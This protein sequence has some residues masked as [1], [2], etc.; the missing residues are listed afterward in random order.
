[1]FSSLSR[2]RIA[3]AAAIFGPL[4]VAGVLIPFRTAISGANM[5]LVLVVAVVAVAAIGNRLAGALAAL[6]AA[7]W[8]DY[9]LTEPYER[10]TIAAN[11]DVLTAILLLVVGL[12]VSQLAARAHRLHLITVTDADQLSWIHRTTQLVQSGAAPNQVVNQVRPELVDLLHLRGCRF[13]EGL[14]LGRPPRLEPD[15]SI[16]PK[17]VHSSSQAGELPD[18]DVELRVSA[19]G[20]YYGRFMLTPTP[21]HAVPLQAR[22]V[23]VTLADQVAEAFDAVHTSRPDRRT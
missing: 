23:A 11:T 10:F 7:V 3:L 1:M 16:T 12:A 21:G 6:S 2:E 5:A 4:A 19:D 8:F 13:E 18:A 15:G 9:F 14:L 17:P 20:V 22:L